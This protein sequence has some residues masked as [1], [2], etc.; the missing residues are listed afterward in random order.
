[1]ICTVEKARALGRLVAA[2]VPCV[3]KLPMSLAR[4]DPPFHVHSF[5]LTEYSQRSFKYP[6]APVESLPLPPKSQRFPEAS[7]QLTALSRAP[8]TLPASGVFGM[9][10][11][12]FWLTRFD[13]LTQVHSRFWIL[14]SHRSFKSPEFVGVGRSSFPPNS[15]R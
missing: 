12:P 10:Y 14:Y 1:M 6:I 11:V 2:A 5:V 8:G 3:P 13:P 15:Q 9:P 7:I 4:F